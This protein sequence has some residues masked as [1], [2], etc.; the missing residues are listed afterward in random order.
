MHIDLR[1]VTALA[2][3]SLPFVS[4]LTAQTGNEVIFV[5]SSTS[6]S[7][8]QHVFA[9]SASGNVLV[10]TGNGFT[11]NIT[12]AVW[13]DTGR[14]LYAGQS[15]MDRVVVADWDGSSAA[16]ST[17]YQSNSACYGVE[18]DLA[19]QRVWT[20]TGGAGTNE[21]VCI[22]VDLNS[23][24]YGQ[25]VAQTTSLSGAARERWGMSYSGNLAAVPTA[26]LQS[27]SFQLVDLNPS[28]A[29]YLQTIVSTPVPSASTGFT[30]AVD[31]AI[32][33][34]DDYAFLLWSGLSD[35]G[36]GVWDIAAG[37]WLDFGAAPGQQDLDI[38]LGSPNLMDLSFDGSFAVISGQGGAGWAARVDFDFQNPQNTTF[39]QYGGLTVP[40]C[41]GISLSPDDSRV[42][43]TSTQ[44]FLSTPSELTVFDAATGTVLQSIALTQMWNVYTTAWQDGSP[45]ARYDT[46]GAGCSGAL[47]VPE[48]AATPGS[49]PA[50][51]SSFTVELTNLPFGVAAMAT[52]LSSTMT[53]SGLP[54]PLDLAAIGMTGCVQ[55]TDALV[56]DLVQQPGTS[57]TWQFAVPSAASLFGVRF[58]NQ[59]YVLDPAA[60]LFGFTAS[61]AGIGQLGF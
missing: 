35:E 33:I 23:P 40:D 50:L 29:T 27:G 22:D 31:S 8:D 13:A 20:L 4:S 44:T 19:R 17:L 60:N 1:H 25:A 15:L 30:F 6:G 14:R 34:G 58:Y 9:E 11:D 47:G 3:V 7:T 51:G 42:A 52:G 36:L 24:N 39:T 21:L 10:A 46:F 55:L 37:A 61:N 49:R 2:V 41:N 43:V 5:G 57:A 59:A 12:S 18:Y 16:W 48:I 26:F 32:S 54:L 56:L 28:S 38:P 53:T 45:L